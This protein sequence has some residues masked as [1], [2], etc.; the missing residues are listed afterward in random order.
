MNIRE[1][2]GQIIS[3]IL[4]T[5][6]E[7]AGQSKVGYRDHTMTITKTCKILWVTVWSTL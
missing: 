3:D 6:R 1:Y 2:A 7:Y 4:T 5:K